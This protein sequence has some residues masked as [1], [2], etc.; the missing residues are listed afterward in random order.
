[1]Y[2]YVIAKSTNYSDYAVMCPHFKFLSLLPTKFHVFTCSLD[3]QYRFI[4]FNEMNLA[5][6]SPLLSRRSTYVNI[7]SEAMKLL[8]D[9]SVNCK[10]WFHGKHCYM[11]K[12][13]L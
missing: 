10:T 8:A 9:V 13:V 12:W 5:V 6:K 3:P 7:L 4:Y 2:D 11:Y 1:M